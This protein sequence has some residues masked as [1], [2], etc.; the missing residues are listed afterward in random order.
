MQTFDKRAALLTE[1]LQTSA[2]I[3][4][5][6]DIFNSGYIMAVKDLL[7]VELDDTKPEEV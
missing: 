4:P 5:R 6:M 7:L 2:G 3:D 1:Q